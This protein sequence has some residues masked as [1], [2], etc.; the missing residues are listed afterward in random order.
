MFACTIYTI[1]VKFLLMHGC[2]SICVQLMDTSTVTVAEHK[3]CVSVRV[4]YAAVL[5]ATGLVAAYHHYC[6][7]KNY[8]DKFD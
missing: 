7:N 1:G 6:Y 8:E 5:C 4:C 3:K 2:Y